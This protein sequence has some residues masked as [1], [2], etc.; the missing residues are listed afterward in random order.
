MNELTPGQVTVA[1]L[2]RELTGIRHDLT[3]VLTGSRLQ[4]ERHT[5]NL[6]QHDD[7]ERRLRLLE[8]GWAKAAGAAAFVAAVVSLATALITIKVR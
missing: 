6:S 4:E 1:D 7:Y 5:T 2:Y 8:R 3:E